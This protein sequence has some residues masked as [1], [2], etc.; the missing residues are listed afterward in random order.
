MSKSA[1]ISITRFNDIWMD[2]NRQYKIVIDGETMGEMWPEK[3][4]YI[5]VEPGPHQVEIKID[6]M[7]SNRLEVTV[8]SGETAEL[9]CRGHG[10]PLAFVHTLIKRHNYLELHLMTDGERSNS[11]LA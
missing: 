4:C 1:T 8:D 6:F 7:G 11:K 10:S 3:T 2:R 5:P 9:A